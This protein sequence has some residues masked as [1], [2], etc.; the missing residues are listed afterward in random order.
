M[1]YYVLADTQLQLSDIDTLTTICTYLSH[2]FRNNICTYVSS[3]IVKLVKCKV[4]VSSEKRV[5]I[6]LK[7]QLRIVYIFLEKVIFSE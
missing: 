2:C 6:L 1:S 7:P 4:L 3:A 5:N